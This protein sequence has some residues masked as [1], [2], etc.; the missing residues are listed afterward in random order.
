MSYLS[1]QIGQSGLSFGMSLI[2]TIRRRGFEEFGSEETSSITR[3]PSASFQSASI[4]PVT[5]DKN[6]ALRAQ[7]N[8]TL[9]AHFLLKARFKVAQSA[10]DSWGMLG[11]EQVFMVERSMRTEPT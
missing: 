4:A 2:W 7:I 6:G 3:W 5:A 11:S 8:N 9:L 10:D 1:V